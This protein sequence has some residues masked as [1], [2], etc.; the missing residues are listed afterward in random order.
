M[1]HRQYAS[2]PF[3]L[4]TVVTI[5]LWVFVSQEDRGKWLRNKEERK[6]AEIHMEEDTVLVVI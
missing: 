4:F 3:F 2:N 6:K 1:L 5:E